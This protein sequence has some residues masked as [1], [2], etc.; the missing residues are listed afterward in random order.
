MNTKYINSLSVMILC[1]ACNAY[2]MQSSFQEMVAQAKKE[3]WT[4]PTPV[5]VD[6][7]K[8]TQ[9]NILSRFGAYVSGLHMPQMS[10]PRFEGARI[11]TAD[12]IEK[13][14][15]IITGALT[16]TLVGSVWK[17]A[18]AGQFNPKHA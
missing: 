4:K 16:V 3:A 13:H 1:V 10:M 11:W 15:S 7:P 2:G 18:K 17:L 8:S 12:T 6:Q 14:P 9:P 5:V